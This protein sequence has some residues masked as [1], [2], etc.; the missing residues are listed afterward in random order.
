MNFKWR[1]NC[2]EHT[3]EVTELSN[4]TDGCLALDVIRQH[5]K[6]SAFLQ[7]NV[8]TYFISESCL[9]AGRVSPP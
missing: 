6:I 7:G 5:C 4:R 9:Y 8:L 2:F 3:P 1:S